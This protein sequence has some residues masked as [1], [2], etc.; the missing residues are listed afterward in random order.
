[1]KCLLCCK[2][3]IGLDP[4]RRIEL[5]H[6]FNWWMLEMPTLVIANPSLVRCS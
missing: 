3:V 1:M 6:L 2:L 4:E 5:E